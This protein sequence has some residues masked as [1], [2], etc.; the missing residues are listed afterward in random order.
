MQR[1]Y[2][3]VQ[4]TLKVLSHQPPGLTR[5]WLRILEYLTKMNLPSSA[6]IWRRKILFCG[7]KIWHSLTLCKGVLHLC[8][9][10]RSKRGGGGGGLSAPSNMMYFFFAGDKLT[11]P[12]PHTQLLWGGKHWLRGTSKQSNKIYS[13]A[14]ACNLFFIL[15]QFLLNKTF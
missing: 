14:T 7:T 1:N 10:C 9:Q 4:R 8:S 6:V 3:H 11:P 13:Y 5:Y 15:T 12:P 2:P